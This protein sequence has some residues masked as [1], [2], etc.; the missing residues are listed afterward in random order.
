M[1]SCDST[2]RNVAMGA[3]STN[4]VVLASNLALLSIAIAALSAD[5]IVLAS[6]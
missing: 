6:N 5:E 4:E 2:F 3:L 1:L